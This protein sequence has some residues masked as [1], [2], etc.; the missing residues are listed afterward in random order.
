MAFQAALS[1]VKLFFTPPSTRNRPKRNAPKQ[2]DDNFVYPKDS[3]RSR[4]PRRSSITLGTTLTDSQ[5][6]TDAPCRNIVSETLPITQG[7]DSLVFDS[8]SP[9]DIPDSQDI[10]H[11]VADTQTTPPSRHS[12]KM[13][14]ALARDQQE[15]PETPPTLSQFVSP[16]SHSTQS[17]KTQNDGIKTLLSSS[18]VDALSSSLLHAGNAMQTEE[19]LKINSLQQE[20]SSLQD[21]LSAANFNAAERMQEIAELNRQLKNNESKHKRQCSSLTAKMDHLQKSLNNAQETITALKAENKQLNEKHITDCDKLHSQLKIMQEKLDESSTKDNNQNGESEATIKPLETEYFRGWWN[22]L[23]AFHKTQ[24]FSFN[25]KMFPTAEHCYQYLK[26]Q[27]H[28]KTSAAIDISRARTPAMAKN[29]AK[30]AIPQSNTSWESKS[31]QTME[32]ILKAKATQCATYRATLLKTRDKM[33]LHNMETDPKWGIGANGAGQNL[34]GKAVMTVREW[35]KRQ[36]IPTPRPLMAIDVPPKNPKVTNPRSVQVSPPKS[37]LVVGNSNCRGLAGRL[38]RKGVQATGLVLRGCPS[39]GIKQ[40]ITTYQS[41]TTPTHVFLHTGDI[42][43]RNGRP[44]RDTTS[45]VLEL[46]RKFPEATILLNAPS[47]CVGELNVHRKMLFLRDTFGRMCQNIP[48]M[49]LIDSSRL[50]LW[51]DIHFTHASQHIL[52]NQIVTQVTE[53]RQYF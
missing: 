8:D 51:D 41:R 26:A 14:S 53:D 34:M 52:T 2:P 18:T 23:S 25:G 13:R 33:L 48:K 37:V 47:A 29:L 42:D 24:P 38:N 16:Q 46:R 17:N 44:L 5:L 50:R 35:L 3:R 36:P 49:R 45:T 31:Q 7:N 30:K 10:P 22:P 40:A 9:V 28:K 32:E 1:Q 6:M 4:R 21:D 39:T 43:A 12:I 19:R 11:F 20:I 15:M 27:H